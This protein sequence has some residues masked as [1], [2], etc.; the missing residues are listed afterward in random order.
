MTGK[1]YVNVADRWKLWGQKYMKI[2]M[3]QVSMTNHNK[4]PQMGMDPRGWSA[5]H[6]AGAKTAP[7]VA[8]RNVT[9]R[10]KPPR[11]DLLQGSALILE[12]TK[13]AEDVKHVSRAHVRHVG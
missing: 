5:W 9:G 4:T 6:A 10:S 13:H 7:K 8:V 1:N 11:C 2:Q 3:T 12:K